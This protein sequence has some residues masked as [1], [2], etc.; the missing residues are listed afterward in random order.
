MSGLV[1][2]YGDDRGRE[3]V[4]VVLEELGALIG[5]EAVKGGMASTLV[6]RVSSPHVAGWAYDTAVNARSGLLG[7]VKE[8]ASSTGE[9]QGI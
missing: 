6:S 8:A 7:V 1:A 4:A 3:R 2:A 9:G 5:L